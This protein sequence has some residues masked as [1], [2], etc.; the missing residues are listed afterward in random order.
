MIVMPS[1]TMSERCSEGKVWSN[2]EGKCVVPIKTRLEERQDQIYRMSDGKGNLEVKIVVES[3]KGVV[4]K[5]T[6]FSSREKAEK[7][8]KA[9]EKRSKSADWEWD[10]FT[11]IIDDDGR[12]IE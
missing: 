10:D 8:M 11:M 12:K 5:A 2:N 4:E 3:H 7:T 9:A 1:K 6:A